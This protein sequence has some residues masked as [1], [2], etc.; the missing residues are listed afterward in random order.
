MSL[1]G[2]MALDFSNGKIN[3]P[4]AEKEDNIETTTQDE[5]EN[6]DNALILDVLNNILE[7][8]LQF[9]E[10]V[11]DLGNRYKPVTKTIFFSSIAHTKK[12][13]DFIYKDSTIYLDRKY[14]RYLI[15]NKKYE[16][17]LNKKLR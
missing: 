14:E 6:E 17:Y 9:K 7:D 12:F 1:S 4:F 2:I 5:L 15:F 11:V 8:E 10:K 13:L 16:E 3:N